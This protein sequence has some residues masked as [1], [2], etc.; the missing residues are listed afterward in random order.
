MHVSLHTNSNTI[1]WLQNGQLR[2]DL[3]CVIFQSGLYDFD[4][5]V[6]MPG[7]IINRYADLSCVNSYE[8][9]GHGHTLS[10]FCSE[11]T[12]S[13]NPYAYL[14]ILWK[15]K[16]GGTARYVVGRMD[17]IPWQSVFDDSLRTRRIAGDFYGQALTEG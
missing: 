12:I 13:L 10:E 15:R 4:I 5:L 8:Q 9:Q 14:V 7:S 2:R 17:N 3:M 11:I 6:S 16:Y 1:F